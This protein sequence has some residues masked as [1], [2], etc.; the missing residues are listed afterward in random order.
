MSARKALLR[1]FDE[2]IQDAGIEVHCN[3]RSYSL[4]RKEG[5]ATAIRVHRERFFPR[6]LAYGN[7]GMGEAFIDRDFT[8]ERGSLAELLTILLRNGVG[9]DFARRPTLVLRALLIRL[10][11]LFT[12]AQRSVRAHYD[13]GP[14]L[15]AAFLD[16]TLTY[17][18][19]YALSPDD[20]LEQL[21]QQKLDRICRKLRLD[22]DSRLLDIGCG[23]GGLLI[24]AATHYGARGVGVTL[25]HDQHRIAQERIAEAGLADRL[26]VRLDDFA[27]IAGPFNRVASVGMIEHLRLA[28]YREFFRYISRVLTADGIG[29]VHGI[30][31]STRRN[32]QDP[33][34]Q[35]YVFPRSNTPSLTELADP[36]ERS[37]L[38]IVDADNIGPH[39][40]PTLRA[41]L[42]RFLQNRGRLDPARYDQRF[43]RMWEYYLACGVAA[44]EASDGA[45]YQV[46]FTKDYPSKR[47]LSRV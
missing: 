47:W 31:R 28:R 34:I 12:G 7:L 9:E 44:A 37:G 26:S 14:D 19:G 1:L 35:K 8:V 36:I 32:Q 13:A 22:S 25:S 16:P 3:P 45:L 6:V 20:S 27:N 17:S 5:P 46:L 42:D 30:S 18:C 41:W 23:F 2:R 10:R 11:N 21:Q 38:A 4:G 43:L 33:F 24:H 40:A 15:F 29:L 39:Y